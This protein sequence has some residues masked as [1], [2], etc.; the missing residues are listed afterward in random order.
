MHGGLPYTSNPGRP[1]R[2]V[3]RTSWVHTAARAGSRG[4]WVKTSFPRHGASA[5]GLPQNVGFDPGR[6][7]NLFV[8]MVNIA[9]SFPVSQQLSPLEV[10]TRPG[11]GRILLA[12]RC[13]VQRPPVEPFGMVCGL[14]RQLYPSVPYPPFQSVK[15][16]V[17]HLCFHENRLRFTPGVAGRYRTPPRAKPGHG[18][19]NPNLNGS[20]SKEVRRW[21]IWYFRSQSRQ[22]RFTG[23]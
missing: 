10:P 12:S 6:C 14:V 11:A 18:D 9:A 4:T 15:R 1:S 17:P 16:G 8:P 21:R 13:A 5:Y 23:F 20:R 3:A 22:R 2:R 7:R 19:R